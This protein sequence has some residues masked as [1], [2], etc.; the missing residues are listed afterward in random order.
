LGIKAAW[1]GL[2]RERGFDACFNSLDRYTAGLEFPRKREIDYKNFG[3]GNNGETMR[4]V[5]T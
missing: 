1:D 4:R 5:L 2:L 3:Y